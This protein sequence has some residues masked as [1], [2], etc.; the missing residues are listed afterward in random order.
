[1]VLVIKTLSLIARQ[2]I[3]EKTL[4]STLSAHLRI[5]TKW[6]HRKEGEFKTQKC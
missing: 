1:M 2:I 6:F 5:K 4:C 3:N